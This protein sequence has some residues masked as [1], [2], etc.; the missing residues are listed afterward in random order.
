MKRFY[1]NPDCVA[2]GRVKADAENF[3]YLKTVLRVKEGDKLR[4]FD[5]RGREY[6]CVV[7][8]I[9]RRHIN[10]NILDVLDNGME[11]PVEICLA[12]CLIKAGN[13][14]FVVEKCTELG[15][16]KFLPVISERTVVRLSGERAERRR[17]RWQKIAKESAK[18]CGGVCCPEIAPVMKFSDVLEESKAWDISIIPWEEERTQNLKE[19]IAG[20]GNCGKIM[21]FIGPEGGWDRKEISSAMEYGVIPV[22]LGKRILRSETAAITAVSVLIHEIEWSE[23]KKNCC[24]DERRGG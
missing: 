10:L 20:A 1:V 9:C 23:K 18:Q 11:L 15:V 4:A 14:E 22:S 5:G 16:K 24:G 13:F 19:V 6:D 8:K 21:V 17:L 2:G 3:H 7:D 12:Q